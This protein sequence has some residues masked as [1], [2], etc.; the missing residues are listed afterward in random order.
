ME[1]QAVFNTTTLHQGHKSDG[2]IHGEMNQFIKVRNIEEP[3][4]GYAA[5]G[6]QA[7]Q[8]DDYG[9][10]NGEFISEHVT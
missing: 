1:P 8:N 5:A 4:W 2:C 10:Q 3:G 9:Q 6:Y 7:Q